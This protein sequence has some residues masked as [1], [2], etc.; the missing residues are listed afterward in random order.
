MYTDKTYFMKRFIF[1]IILF[2]VVSDCIAQ[3]NKEL[4]KKIELLYNEAKAYAQDGE[5]VKA[6][7][8]LNQ[9]LKND[10]HYA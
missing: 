1:F 6:I 10:P 8:V 5:K 4:I 2:V 3:N 9:V 7:A